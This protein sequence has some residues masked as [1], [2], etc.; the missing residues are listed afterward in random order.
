ME[1]IGRIERRK[2]YYV[3]IRNNST[4]KKSIPKRDWLAF[5][6]ADKEDEELVPPIVKKITKCK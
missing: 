4:W 2:V 1:L 3:Q 6:I 5:T